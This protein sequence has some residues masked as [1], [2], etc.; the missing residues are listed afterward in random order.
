MA[1]IS[2]RA[3]LLGA[4]G[5]SALSANIAHAQEPLQVVTSF[6]IL[7]DMVST[8]GGDHVSVTSLV[9]PDGDAHAFS[10][11]PADAQSLA[12]ADLVV[13]NGLQ[14]EGWIDRLVDAGFEH[15]HCFCQVF[16]P[17][18]YS[19]LGPRWKSLVRCF[20]CM[21]CILSCAFRPFSSHFVE[22]GRIA[23]LKNLVIRRFDPSAIDVI[24]IFH[25]SPW[26]FGVCLFEK[27]EIFT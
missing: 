19:Y 1:H 6:S 16:C 12:D 7:D 15:V 17:P 14:F 25:E 20:N 9:G 2:L 22:V 27:A 3:V 18:M 10:A 4:L 24:L 5:A 8:I 23:L 21:L 11:K 13:V 26:W